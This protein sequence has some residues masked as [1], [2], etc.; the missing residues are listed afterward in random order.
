ML[1]IIIIIIISFETAL[2][3]FHFSGAD[4]G[5]WVATIQRSNSKQA[6]PLTR[7]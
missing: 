2:F 5:G 7:N 3:Q 6:E 1:I 4:S